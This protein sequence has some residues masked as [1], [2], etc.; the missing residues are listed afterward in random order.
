MA[1]VKQAISPVP[2]DRAEPG[3]L[4]LVIGPENLLADRAVARLIELARQADRDLDL[5]SLDAAS[6]DQS[7]VAAAGGS[8]FAERSVV[9]VS[10]AGRPA[11]SFL[12]EA[13][14]YAAN[15]NP[16][17]MV[18]FRHGGGSE[19]KKLVEALRQAGAIEVSAAAVRSD[20]DKAA[21]AAGEFRRLGRSFEPAVVPLLVQ[22]VGS[23]LGELA[24]AVNQVS[25]DAPGRVTVKIAESYYGGRLETTGFKVA[26]AAVMGETGEALRLARF[27][28]NSGL[29][30][31]VLIAALAAKLRTLAIVGGATRARVDPVSEYGLTRW[32]ADQARRVLTRWNPAGLAQAIEATAEA[33]AQVKGLGGSSVKAARSYALERAIITVAGCASGPRAPARRPPGS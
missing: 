29:D 19:S 11:G 12:E 3:P 7:L 28:L 30:P 16:D 25:A 13:L 5:V 14:D 24:A 17:A 31:L 2:W 1:T 23:D 4:V 6:P 33:D 18:I 9:V 21:F 8:L 20:R 27:A 10:G 15:P 32:Q 22:A 26:D